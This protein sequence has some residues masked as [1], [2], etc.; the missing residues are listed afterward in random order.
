M[1][2]LDIALN[3][4]IPSVLRPQSVLRPHA[5]S[6]HIMI[7][8]PGHYCHSRRH[9]LSVAGRIDGHLASLFV[10]ESVFVVSFWVCFE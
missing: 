8:L 4:K 9:E 2:A 5:D 1:P 6:R 10:K 3:L 7:T